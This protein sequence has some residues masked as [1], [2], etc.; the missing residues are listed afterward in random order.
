MDLNQL[1]MERPPAS[2]RAQV[3]RRSGLAAVLGLALEV[4][5]LVCYWPAGRL[6]FLLYEDPFGR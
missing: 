1:A 6:A 3:G 5:T 2:S 4:G